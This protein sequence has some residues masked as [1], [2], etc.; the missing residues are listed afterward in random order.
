VAT[1][2]TVNKACG[3]PDTV[4][5][6]DPRTISNLMIDIGFNSPAAVAVWSNNR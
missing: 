5:D 1:S 4:V 2:F 6:A 3:I